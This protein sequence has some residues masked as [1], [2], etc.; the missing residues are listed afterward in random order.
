VL[1]RAA[2]P[3]N[4]LTED[5]VAARL[6]GRWRSGVPLSLSPTDD[7][8][9]GIPE[10]L[11]NAFDY[12]THDGYTPPIVADAD[13]DRCPL[14]AH[15]RRL[16]PR[17]GRVMGLPN[18]R[19]IIR[20]NMPY[21]PELQGTEDDGRQRGL[22][23]YFFCGDLEAQ[24]EFLQR[25]YVNGSIASYGIR[26]TSDV[27]GVQPN[28]GGRLNV[29]TGGTVIDEIP[30]LVH[31]RGSLYCLLPGRRGLRYLAGERA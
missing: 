17:G 4:G 29:D 9:H 25:A 20:R 31:T 15:V 1:G 23:G 27:F 7:D 13:G 8:E 2:D 10:E 21:G 11:R 16:N 26:G 12:V 3:A 18:S 24:W 14:G 22:V 30:T 5:R 19:R 6:V 28:E